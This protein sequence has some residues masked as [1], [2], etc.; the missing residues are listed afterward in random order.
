MTE[1]NGPNIP[2]PRKPTEKPPRPIIPPQRAEAEFFARMAVGKAS[3]P[4][5]LGHIRVSVSAAFRPESGVE[6]SGKELWVQTVPA[7]AAEVHVIGDADEAKEVIE[8]LTSAL[9]SEDL[10]GGWLL[11][12]VYATEVVPG[13]MWVDVYPDAVCGWKLDAATRTFQPLRPGLVLTLLAEEVSPSP[14]VV[15]VEPI[16][17]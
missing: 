3:V 11:S 9:M 16:G 15:E 14:F 7:S 10:S 12:A 13:G 8:F 17:G 6:F 2:N 5:G 4:L 1:S